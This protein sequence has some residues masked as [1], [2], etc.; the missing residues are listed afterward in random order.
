MWLT[1]LAILRPV[2]IW[3][4]FGAIAVLGWRSMREMQ[5]ELNP[6]V[7]IPYVSVSTTYPGAGPE[8]IETLVTDKIEEAVATANNVDHLTSISREGVSPVSIQF[9]LLA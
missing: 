9:S 7:D 6:R 2:T 5:V 4:L 3:M 8:E 1:R